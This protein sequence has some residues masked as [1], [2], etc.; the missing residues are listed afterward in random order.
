M[1]SCVSNK[2]SGFGGSC[3]GVHCTLSR[4]AGQVYTCAVKYRYGCL[5]VIDPGFQAGCMFFPTMTPRNTTRQGAA[6]VRFKATAVSRAGPSCHWKGGIGLPR[7]LDY[8]PRRFAT[9]RQVLANGLKYV[10][11]KTASPRTPSSQQ[12]LVRQPCHSSRQRLYL[13]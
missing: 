5:P 13:S 8:T 4:Q 7:A 3:A 10:S 12:P 1:T 2:L 9:N 11:S 6:C